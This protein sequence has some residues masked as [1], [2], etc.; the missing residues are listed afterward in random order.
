LHGTLKKTWKQSSRFWI[1]VIVTCKRQSDIV[2]SRRPWA[3]I[4]LSDVET[5]VGSELV[6]VTCKRQSDI[7]TSRRPW[8]VI[9][10][11]DV[12]TTD[13]YGFWFPVG[14]VSGSDSYFLQFC[15]WML[16]RTFGL[17]QKIQWNV[18]RNRRALEQETQSGGERTHGRLQSFS[19]IKGVRT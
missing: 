1:I 15:S 7:V 18:S 4:T 6:I 12:E 11:S 5:T 8:A 9:T 19:R 16:L 17:V 13:N 10:P 2:T 3:V 14:F